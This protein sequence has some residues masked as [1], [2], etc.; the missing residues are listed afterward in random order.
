MQRHAV[1]GDGAHDDAVV[2][3]LSRSEPYCV[4]GLT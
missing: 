2:L 3:I 1:L 4:C